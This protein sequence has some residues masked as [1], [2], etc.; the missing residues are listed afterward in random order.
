MPRLTILNKDEIKAFDEP[1]KFTLLQ[2]EKYFYIN[3]KLDTLLKTLREP[4]YKLC[5]ILQWGYFRASGRFFLIKD[6][7]LSDVKYVCGLL[8]IPYSRV[9]LEDYQNKRKTI[10]RHKQTILKAINFRSF[11]E[12]EKA[13][14]Q[15][16]LANLVAKQMQPREIIY[17]LASQC[18]QQQIEIPSYHYFAE[19]ITQCYNQAELDLIKIIDNNISS[20]Q[21]QKLNKLLHDQND[22]IPISQW[23][24]Y[25]QKLQVKQI[26]AELTLFSDVKDSFYL[27]LNLIEKLDLNPSSHEYYATWVHKAKM[28]QLKQMANPAKL[29]L[30]LTAFVQHQF[31]VRQDT[32][33]DIFLKSVQTMRNRAKKKRLA[34]EQLQRSEKNTLI[35]HLIEEQDRLETMVADIASIINE[36]SLNDQKKVSEIKALLQKHQVIQTEIDK[37]GHTDNKKK[38]KQLLNDDTYYILLEEIS[39]SLQRRVSNIVRSVDFDE[40]TSD[41]AIIEAINYYKETNGNVTQYAPVD[42]LDNKQR[43]ICFANNGKIRI[44][45]YKALLFL[46]M[47]EHI[48]SGHLNLKYSY[49]YKAI[50]NYLIPQTKWASEKNKLLTMAGLADFVDIEQVLTQLKYS[51]DRTYQAVNE[52]VDTGD[53]DHIHF[54]ADGGYTLNTSKLIKK[55]MG[56]ISELLNESGFVPIIQILSDVNRVTQFTDFFKHYSVKNQKLKPTPTT[57][58]AGIMAKGHNIGINKISH[59]SV[60]ING[61]TLRQTVNWFFTHKNIQTANNK[62]IAMINKLSLSNVFKY[63]PELTHTSSDGQKY[64]VT[65]DSLLANYSFKYFGKDKGVTVYTFIDDKHSLFYSTVISASEREAAYVIDGLLHNNVVKSDI[66]STD[67]HGFTETIF[68]A[69]HFIGTSFAPRFKN[70]SHQRIYGFSTK[71]TYANKGYKI[72]PSRLINQSIIREHWD[73][74]LRFMATIKLK[75]ANASVLLKRLSSYTK[76]H[77]L[78]KAIKEFG[79]IIK[80]QFILTYIDELP[81]RQHIEKQLNKVELSNKFAKAVFFEKNQEFTV[82]TREEQEIVANCKSLIQ[83]AIVLWNYL[84]LS[85]LI[86]NTSSCNAKATL[87]KTIQN[88]SMQTWQHINM[89]G[90][91]DFTKAAN[92]VNFDMNKILTLKIEEI[93]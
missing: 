20:V 7:Y 72:L 18:H 5:I 84:Y 57:I 64:Q 34:N 63:Q 54:N 17:Y 12:T 10:H 42:F 58:I 76:D 13:W 16:Q 39:I 85:Q 62:I 14:L 29:Y 46:Y 70:I 47:A 21:K 2:R 74:I 36:K 75:E 60:G 1:P 93:G 89:R 77:P 27:L 24:I 86:I 3:E 81:L 61:N 79:R 55:N 51:L 25:N 92:S 41:K 48:K 31:Y 28:S 43:K 69:T 73:D 11:D 87:F 56:S 50:Q 6:F 66:H 22:P 23:K 82:A 4:T 26:Q 30:Y 33:L 40:S 80:S 78:Y 35:K 37:Q 38:L 83:N 49:R 53:N 32:L 65:V 88:G 71:Q 52:R 90:E 45:L 15:D 59:I 44:S 8:N 19:C 67:M 91:Y 68:A 9:Y